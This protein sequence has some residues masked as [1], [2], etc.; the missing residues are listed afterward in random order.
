M[1]AIINGKIITEDSILEN[2]V[3]LFDEK[4]IDIVDEK[5]LDRKTTYVID[6]EGN[7]VSPGFI[8]VHIHGF[9]GADTMDGSL[10]A[11]KTISRD[12]TKNGV[13][14]FLPTTMTMDRQKIYTALDTIREASTKCLGGA[15]ILGAHLEGP[16]ISEKF[17]GAQAKTH[18]LKP[19]YDFIK[20]Y[21]DIIKII[22]LAPEEDE[23]LEF[24]KTVKKNSDIVLSIGHSNASY[25]EA[26]NAIKNGI[27]H[28]THMFN[29][30]T[31]LTHRNLGIIGAI[32]NNNIP[33]EIIADKI[34]LH[35]DIYKI[36]I[37][38]I[39]T[40]NITLITDCMRAGGLG[41]GVSELG[42]Q[43]VIVKDDSARL[44]NGTLAGS[45]LTLNKAIKNVY[46]NTDLKLNEVV[47]LATINPAKNINV[48]DKKGSLTNGKD[49]DI[50]IFNDAFEIKLTIIGGDI[51][52]NSN[53]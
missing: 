12:I 9:S 43:K 53:C 19:D 44:E 17:K 2:K 51:I 38:T 16:F 13:T 10:D 31:P 27:N 48:F 33:S 32:F 11:L 3:L 23:N 36:L 20:D 24:I 30:M 26:V 41:D 42:G 14:S 50:T 49:S 34:H 1:K 37:K 4:I 35:P 6:A 47:K 21:I 28:V 22:T 15:K 25:D 5:N 45:I 29:A 39:G 18:I 7:Y 40:N 52:E 46:E 8:D